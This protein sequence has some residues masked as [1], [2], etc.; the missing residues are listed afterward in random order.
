MRSVWF[1]RVLRTARIALIPMPAALIAMR[2]MRLALPAWRTVAL[3]FFRGPLKAPQ[4]LAQ[5]V[6]LALVGGLLPLGFL[7]HFQH[8]IELIQRFT[9][10]R[11][12]MHHLINRLADGRRLRG[13]GWWGRRDFP[14]AGG[15]F[16]RAWV[17]DGGGFGGL[18]LRFVGDVD[19]R[20]G[21]EEVLI[22]GLRGFGRGPFRGFRRV[23]GRILWTRIRPGSLDGRL[24]GDGRII[25]DRLAWRG[26]A[27]VTSSAPTPTPTTAAGTPT[28][29]WGRGTLSRRRRR[30]ISIRHH[31]RR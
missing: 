31:V 23:A 17:F 5:R 14:R 8:L 2:A 9:Q 16:P 11:D 15:C 21:R 6:D 29:V 19:F 28:A 25:L 27:G 7:E 4:L 26:R 10:G 30:G 1:V 20:R 13:A 24:G 18:L 12:D 3:D 22:L